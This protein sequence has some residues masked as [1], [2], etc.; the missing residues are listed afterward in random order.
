MR[1][2]IAWKLTLYFA[3]VLLVFA[4]VVGGMFMHFFSQH[5]L[6]MKKDEL[7]VRATKVAEVLEDNISRVQNRYGGLSSSRFIRYMDNITMDN[8]WIIDED[9]NVKMQLGANHARTGMGHNRQSSNMHRN[10]FKMS[11]KME[12]TPEKT[13]D[14]NYASLSTG[15]RDSIERSFAGNNFV[16]EEYN[17]VLGTT[18]VTVGVPAKD[19]EGRVRAVVLLHASVEDMRE[20]SWDGI[21]ILILSCIVALI[22]VFVLSMMFSWKFTHPLNKMRLIAEKMA[23]HD[24]TERCNIEQKDEIGQLAKTLDGLGERLL[25]ADIASKK[26][27]Q[28]RRDFIAN[29]SHELRTP[30]TVIRGSLEALCDKI[31][32]NPEEV[33]DYH[34]QMLSETL[35][36]QRLINDL[37]DLS[38][39]QNV[40]F[41]IEKEPLNLCDVVHDAVRGSSHLGNGKEIELEL[42]LDKEMYMLEGDYGRLR[43]MLMIFLD[44][45]I[46]FSPVGGKIEVT[47]ANNRLMVTDY[48]SGVKP[49]DLP[50]V[51]DRF[52]KTRGE[53][54]KSG[55]GLGL[56]ISKQIAERHGIELIMLSAPEKGTSI[57]MKLP[58]E[59][60]KGSAE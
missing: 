29:I 49:E 5:M 20:T 24:Y 21:K 16:L 25:A 32:T 13:S 58:P 7:Q 4:L 22:L 18:V 12:D 39:L 10:D 45:S 2:K 47:L 26:L 23:E 59:I 55:S 36:L 8:V 51:F 52:Y 11:C 60:E 53:T 15:V 57:V 46:K 3:A 41:P 31:V 37:L 33:E 54:N 43:Q 27:E 34:K 48:G 30:V 35:F 14:V 28:L 9:R 1:N 6:E 19:R 42:K 44:N 56:A 17:E 50:H 40:D 38:R